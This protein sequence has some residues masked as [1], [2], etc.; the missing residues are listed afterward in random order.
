M[1]T[2]GKMDG[3][4]AIFTVLSSRRHLEASQLLTMSWRPLSARR[5]LLPLCGPVLRPKNH[6]CFLIRY[7]DLAHSSPLPSSS[8]SFRLRSQINVM[9]YVAE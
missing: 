8:A 4:H 5:V 6:C 2:N 7:Y 3:T 1:D 9:R